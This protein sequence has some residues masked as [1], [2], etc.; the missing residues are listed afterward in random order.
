MDSILHKLIVVKHFP[1]KEE[2][3]KLDK[4]NIVGSHEEAPHGNPG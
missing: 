1:G 3:V 2:K 4:D